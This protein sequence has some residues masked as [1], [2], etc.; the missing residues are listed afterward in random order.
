M[1]AKRVFPKTP[2]PLRS[3]YALAVA[4][5]AAMAAVV[6][7]VSCVSH[8]SKPSEP[9]LPS[10]VELPAYLKDT[11]S[12][13][14]SIVGRD[15]VPVECIGFVTNLD[16]T[17]TR[18]VPPGIRTEIIEVMKR[19]KVDHPEVF[20][21]DTDNAVVMVTGF[22]PPGINKGEH[23]DLEVRAIPGTDT[24][25]LEGGFL[26]EG[27]MS[28][29]LP[30]RG[31]A[32][33]GE[34]LSLGR[35]SIFVSPFM[36]DSGSKDG[37]DGKAAKEPPKT[38]DLRVGRILGGG[39]A[40]KT[41]SFQLSLNNPSARTADQIVRMVNTRFPDAA[42]GNRDPGRVDLEAPREFQD[43]KAHFLDLVGGLYLREGG[44]ARDQ[45]V[46]ELITLLRS[47]Q[48]MDRVA[49]CLESFG[50]SVAPRLH[51]LCDDPKESLRYYVARTLA[52]LQDGRAVS[53]L[54]AI[55]MNDQSE[56][57]EAAAEALGK[58]HNGTGVG[59]LG[60]AL[61]VK[62]ARVRVAAWQ[63]MQQ[64]NPRMTM[65]RRFED[66]FALSLVATR[67]DPFIYVARTMRPQI[68]IF[69]DVKVTAPVL[70]ET[71]RVTASATA[72]PAADNGAGS[73]RLITRRRGS[74]IH[75]D[76]T[77]DIK[78]VIVKLA[79]PVEPKL[80]PDAA[81]LAPPGPPQGL[82]LSYSDVV[83]LLN[84]LSRKHA[85]SAPI[86]L[87]PLKLYITGDRPV[88]RPIDTAKEGPI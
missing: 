62:S 60:R 18:S 24:T 8:A 77:L 81:A 29:V 48:D 17:G 30:A 80:D 2:G 66:K 36:I 54:D 1:R 50:P 56:F 5:L 83:G 4:G 46:G 68:A 11:V 86:V 27:D 85:L 82:G 23:F 45:R 38:G 35:G 41:R 34:I 79:T 6:V 49:L 39:K 61:N 9:K 51:A 53:V 55:V 26:L 33:R 47:G 42:K 70:A 25:S 16:G 75:M 57:Q 65:V 40:L 32:V 63:A 87:Q 72:N 22:M 71:P 67:G 3:P 7:A 28:R 12:E 10:E 19:N 69:G 76:A 20:I 64:V 88:A 58:I 43:D 74:D 37:A 14:A 31:M 59:V 44:A 13:V 52:N 21:G 78:D 15:D 84:E 73:I